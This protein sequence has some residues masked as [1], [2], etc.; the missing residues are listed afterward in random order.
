MTLTPQTDPHWCH[1]TLPPATGYVQTNFCV[2]TSRAAKSYPCYL[3]HISSPSKSN[4]LWVHSKQY[5]GHAISSA[6][7]TKGSKD[8]SQSTI[9]WVWMPYLGHPTVFINFDFKMLL[10]IIK[11]LTFQMNIQ[12]KLINYSVINALVSCFQ[13][14]LLLEVICYDV[15][16][17]LDLDFEQI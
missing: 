8:L 4:R 1:L 5:V 6:H 16:L 11:Q 17:N 12:G 9:K 15:S 3:A 13:F 10:D 2:H 7:L 14:S